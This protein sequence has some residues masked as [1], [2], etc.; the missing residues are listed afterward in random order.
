MYFVFAF[1]HLNTLDYL[2]FTFIL[3]T[4]SVFPCFSVSV[5]L[6]FSV[7]VFVCSDLVFGFQEFLLGIS[8]FLGLILVGFSG[9]VFI[10]F[11]FTFAFEYYI[12]TSAFYTR[13]LLGLNY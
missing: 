7:S 10:S 4:V 12:F 11:L 5:H 13:L 2:L 1:G 8:T 6:D 3:S 9:F